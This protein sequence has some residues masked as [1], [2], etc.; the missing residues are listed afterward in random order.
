LQLSDN[1][2]GVTDGTGSLVTFLPINVNNALTASYISGVT[3]FNSASLLTTASVVNNTITFTKGNNSQFS[4]TIATGS[5]GTNTPTFPYT[6]S[7]II[8][9][10]LTITGSLNAQ[11]ITGSLFGTASWASNALTASR[12]LSSNGSTF[13]IQ[14]GGGASGV[15]MTGSSNFQYNGSNVTLTNGYL[16]QSNNTSYFTWIGSYTGVPTEMGIWA[17]D[18]TTENTYLIA[19]YD[20]ATSKYS[21]AGSNVTYDNANGKFGIGTTTPSAKLQVVGNVVATSFTGSLFGTASYALTSSF[22]SQAISASNAT[23]AS[24]AATASYLSSLESEL[25]NVLIFNL[26]IS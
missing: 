9:G 12:V 13:A 4:L 2:T 7:A 15:L 14:Y 3:T 24:Y 23:S 1:G 18:T 21:F 6:G 10:S 8:S 26:F 17:D 22:A 11:F 16:A 20:T 5:V 19:S 25:N